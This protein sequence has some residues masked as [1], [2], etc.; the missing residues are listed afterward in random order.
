MRR[1]SD[2]GSVGE[3]RMSEPRERPNIVLI[4]TDQQRGD[5]TG[6]DGH[7]LLQTPHLDQLANEGVYFA[8]AYSPCPVCVPARMCVMTGQSPYRVGYFSNSGQ[9][10]AEAEALP[11]LLGR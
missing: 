3:T 9:T 10:L 8:R 4:T 5:C 6:I 2:G 11:R 1:T 7:P